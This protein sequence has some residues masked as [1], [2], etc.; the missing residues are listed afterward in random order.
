MGNFGGAINL[1]PKHNEIWKNKFTIIG[2]S[3]L[4]ALA[5]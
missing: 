5:L 3:C 2:N 1:N 4:V